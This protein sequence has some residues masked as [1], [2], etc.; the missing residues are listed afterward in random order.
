MAAGYHSRLS[1]LAAL[2][3]LAAMFIVAQGLEFDIRSS[4]ASPS[5]AI[6]SGQ[7]RVADRRRP[8]A[9]VGAGLCSSAARAHTSSN[10]PGRSSSP[11]AFR[12]HS[13][14]YSRP[15]ADF[16]QLPCPRRASPS[17][18]A[19]SRRSAPRRS[20]FFHLPL[21]WNREGPL[22]LP[23]V[24][25][26]GIWLSILLAIGVTTGLSASSHRGGAQAGQHG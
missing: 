4:L 21:P 16:R 17:H 3:Q 5:S 24:Y 22:V 14:S 8:D 7:A 20:G 13:R 12:N 19:F 15:G 2:G 6:G 25:M 1:S 9:A 26:A 18:S 23:P 11:A 10:S